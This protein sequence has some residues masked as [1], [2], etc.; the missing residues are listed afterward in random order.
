MVYIWRYVWFTQ[1][2]WKIKMVLAVAHSKA[3]QAPSMAS[4]AGQT[5][6]KA[7]ALQGFTTKPWKHC[8][9]KAEG[10]ENAGF[11]KK[12]SEFYRCLLITKVET[13]I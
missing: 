2:N 4:F 11:V 12:C 8:K 13:G 9:V 10:L 5:K 7:K 3:L 1:G 6:R